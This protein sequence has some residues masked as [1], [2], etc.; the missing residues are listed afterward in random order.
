MTQY[1][2]AHISPT[3]PQGTT[4]NVAGSIILASVCGST[5]PTVKD[6]L[7]VGSFPSLQVNINEVSN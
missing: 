2:L 7:V 1:P 4:S 5:L 3:S 6:F